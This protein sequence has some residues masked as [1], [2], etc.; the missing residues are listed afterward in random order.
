LPKE[1]EKKR[2]R[3]RRRRRKVNKNKSLVYTKFKKTMCFQKKK[4][5]K[6]EEIFIVIRKS[7]YLFIF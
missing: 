5:K 2:R 6:I 7:I 3:R 4:T 1:L